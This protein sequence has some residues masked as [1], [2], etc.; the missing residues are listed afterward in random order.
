M[1]E[2]L[3]GTR[4]APAAGAGGTKAMTGSIPMRCN[5]RGRLYPASAAFYAGL[6]V[7]VQR[8]LTDNGNGYRSGVFRQVVTGAGGGL[9]HPALSAPVEWQDR[10]AQP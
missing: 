10:A 5:H 2:S 6:G 8:V 3:A 7:T 4:P 9:A 1:A